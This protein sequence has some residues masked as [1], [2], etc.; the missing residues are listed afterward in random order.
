MHPRMKWRLLS[1][2]HSA[3]FSSGFRGPRRHQ[4]HL[5]RRGVPI[6]LE[7]HPPEESLPIAAG[8]TGG[9]ARARSI[10]EEA[11]NAYAEDWRGL[12]RCDTEAVV[13]T[14]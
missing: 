12:V 10:A 11:L 13:S 2:K 9:L 1:P 5:C 8:R 4:R 7:C 3:D 14:S 6:S